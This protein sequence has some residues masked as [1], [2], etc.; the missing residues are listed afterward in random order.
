[1]DVT[2]NLF[3]IAGVILLAVIAG[4]F[5]GR[6]ERKGTAE[7]A[8]ELPEPCEGTERREHSALRRGRENGRRIPLGRSIASPASGEVHLLGEEGGCGAV[9][10]PEEG[11]I[12]APASGKI[13][14]L[15]PMGNA[16]VLR[17][18]DNGEL[19]IRVGREPDELCNL[20][21]RP[22]IVQNEIV[23][24]GKL[25]MVYD[26]EQL[27]AAGEDI[28]VTVSLQ[29]GAVGKEVALIQ[30]GRVKAGEELMKIY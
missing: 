28:S 7:E 4:Y 25:L 14:R 16:F 10:V 8:E 21:F 20:C 29:S 2:I 9:I 13:T 17:M 5:I 19:L 12:Y 11:K 26:R 15:F 6:G 23:N 27:Q 22:R 30:E 24:K 18:E 1:M 3:G